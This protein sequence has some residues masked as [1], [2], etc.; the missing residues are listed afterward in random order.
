MKPVAASISSATMLLTGAL[1]AW[2]ARADDRELQAILLKA[3]CVP[4]KVMS[5]SI[6]S[7]LA[8]YEVTCKGS[9]KVLHI[10]CRKSECSLQPGAHEDD[11]R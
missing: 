3:G 4:S 8:A 10:V 2:Q 11:E 9:G 1:L 7:N 5:T 6:S